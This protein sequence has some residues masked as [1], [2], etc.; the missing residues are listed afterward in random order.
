MKVI[1]EYIDLDANDFK[2]K[3]SEE[4]DNFLEKLNSYKQEIIQIKE[5]YDIGLFKLKTEKLKTHIQ[6]VIQNTNKKFQTMIPK[7]IFEKS[8]NLQK[9][10][11]D[12][13]DKLS[14]VCKTVGD[15]CSYYTFFKTMQEEWNE[16]F[17]ENIN[18]QM[19]KELAKK[20]TIKVNDSDYELANSYTAAVE[21]L[22]NK[23]QETEDEY[24][25]KWRKQLEKDIPDLDRQAREIQDLIE[26][27][28][29]DRFVKEEETIQILNE[30][31]ENEKQVIKIKNNV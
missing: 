2:D 25:D 26:N 19:L 8:N 16:H 6:Y 10:L 1:E 17:G 13:R 12:A 5:D 3:S 28:Y 18:I 31:K 4:I 22:L 15:F 9:I 24:K 27:E 29:F 30:I 14:K 7:L 23:A 20:Y 11:K 21:D